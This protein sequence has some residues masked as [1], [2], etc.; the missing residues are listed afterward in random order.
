MKPSASSVRGHNVR[1]FTHS[2]KHGGERP[3]VFC[4]GMIDQRSVFR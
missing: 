4:P 3:R 1:V 2:D